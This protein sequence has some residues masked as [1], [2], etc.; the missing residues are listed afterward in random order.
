MWTWISELWCRNVHTKAMWPMHGKYIFPQCLREY[1]VAWEGP[2]RA[3]EYADPSL[4]SARIAMA[5]APSLV[6]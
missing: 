3:A 1:R 4:C 6:Q 5:S 2:V